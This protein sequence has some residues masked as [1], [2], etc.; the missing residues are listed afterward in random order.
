MGS[1]SESVSRITLCRSSSAC[2]LPLTR[3]NLSGLL[4]MSEARKACLMIFSSVRPR[5]SSDGIS[6]D[7]IWACEA[8]T[9]SGVFTSWATPAASS[10]V[11]ES[12]SAWTN[13]SSRLTRS[14]RS[15]RISRRPI[16]RSGLA[17]SGTVERLTIN[18]RPSA[19]RNWTLSLYKFQLRSADGR[20]LIVNLSTVPLVAKPDRVI[21]RLLILDDLTERVSLE[22]QLV[23]A[24]KLSSTGLLAAGVAHE[25]N[26]PLA[27]IASQAQM[28]SREIPSD[29]PRGRT[30]EK[31]IKQ[32]FRAS[33]IVNNLLKFSRVSGSE[34]AEL[35]LNKV[36]RETLSLVEPMLRSSK[37]TVNA[38]LTT[39]LPAI[40]GSFGKLQQV[41]MNLILNARDAMPHGGDLVI[42][43]E[44]ENSTVEGEVSDNGVGVPTEHGDKNF[45]PFFTTKA[46]NPGTRLGLAVTYGII[47]EHSGK[48]R[49]ESAVGKG[50]SF[51]LEFPTA[52]KAVNV[53]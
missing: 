45:D 26:T 28:L 34:Y 7:S 12:F 30:L 25:V 22:D 43:T 15:S 40:Y 29:D 31:I 5:G 27:V 41:F 6:G 48:I 50:T 23:Q 21:G 37:I 10:P 51:Q 42:A 32:A 24:E 33:E 11:E 46:T 39:D 53:S 9:A 18:C 8:I 19:E 4:T 49:V 2:S 16:T 47:R 17:T 1:T 35:D 36:I 52:R 44:S 13:W 20:Q 38:Q 14:V 3:E